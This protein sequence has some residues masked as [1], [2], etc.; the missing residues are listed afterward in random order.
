MKLRALIGAC[1]VLGAQACS[2]IE[3]DDGLSYAL[4]R[5]RLEDRR[6]LAEEARMNRELQDINRQLTYDSMYY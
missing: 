3:G 6:L 2:L 4:Y 5:A 1:T